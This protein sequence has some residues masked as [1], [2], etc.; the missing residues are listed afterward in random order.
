MQY[1][2]ENGS[3]IIIKD[4]DFLML[5]PPPPLIIVATG[6]VTN[7]ALFASF[8]NWFDTAVEE[9][10]NGQAVVEIDTGHG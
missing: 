5:A 3:V 1:A 7:Q 8:R 4:S 10:A 9:L 2:I 6:N